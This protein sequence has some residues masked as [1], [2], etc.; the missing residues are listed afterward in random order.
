MACIIHNS[1]LP[2][3][4]GKRS[5]S[6]GVRSACRQMS[7]SKCGGENGFQTMEAKN[8]FAS[9]CRPLAFSERLDSSI[10]SFHLERNG[11]PIIVT[12][13]ASALPSAD[14][15]LLRHNSEAIKKICDKTFYARRGNDCDG[16][17]EEGNRL[18]TDK[19]MKQT[20]RGGQSDSA[21]G[22]IDLRPLGAGIPSASRM[23]AQ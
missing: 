4:E 2:R 12:P 7:R 5:A 10:P 11:Q 6:A 16:R 22:G 21:R 3:T 15:A 17:K 13:I 14:R 18:E 23:S 1:C 19:E 20:S 8:R 9:R